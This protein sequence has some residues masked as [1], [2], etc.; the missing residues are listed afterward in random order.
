MAG[1]AA[2][3]A[4]LAARPAQAVLP[5]LCRLLHPASVTALRANGA[6]QLRLCRSHTL[7]L[8]RVL[9]FRGFFW[10]AVDDD[11]L[12]SESAGAE[13]PSVLDTGRGPG[14][15]WSVAGRRD[16]RSHRAARPSRRHAFEDE[17]SLSRFVRRALL[18]CGSAT[19][20]IGVSYEVVAASP[21]VLALL[22]QLGLAVR[23]PP[24]PKSGR[25]A[26]E[27]LGAGPDAERIAPAWAAILAVHER[28]RKIE[29]VARCRTEGP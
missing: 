12:G 26:S 23:L 25:G 16:P 7:Y 19:R 22:T 18:R 8:V 29:R 5:L 20:R 21:S 9:I 10:D 27:P 24:A 4:T 15:V 11:C 6:R 2:H 1:R 17:A 3:R 14:S 13:P 28:L